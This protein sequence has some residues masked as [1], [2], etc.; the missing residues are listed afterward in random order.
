MPNWETKQFSTKEVSNA[1][2]AAAST[3]M[4]ANQPITGSKIESIGT[5]IIT[6]SNINYNSSTAQLSFS[7]YIE[8]TINELLSGP[9]AITIPITEIYHGNSTI[10][11]VTGNVLTVDP[12]ATGLAK[13]ISITAAIDNETVNISFTPTINTHT[14]ETAVYY[15]QAS[16]TP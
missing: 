8:V 7:Y 12:D 16:T 11:N 4:I 10:P 2:F 9:Q 13:D 1:T 15:M 6:F 3:I 5:P 14:V